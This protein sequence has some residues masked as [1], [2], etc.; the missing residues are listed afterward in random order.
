MDNKIINKDEGIDFDEFIAWRKEKMKKATQTQDL[1]RPRTVAEVAM[2]RSSER[3]LEAIAP[4]TGY[5]ELT[6][7]LKGFIPGHLYVLTGETNIGKS[8]IAANFAVRLAR[9]QKKVCYVALEPENTIVD[10]LASVRFDKKYEDLTE[11]DIKFDDGNIHIYG[12]EEI[13]KIGDLVT[14]V[15]E[16][17]RYDLII[18]DHISYFITGESQNIFV[19]QSNV[20]KKLA[21]LAKHKKTAIL[22]IA[23]L[24]KPPT[25]TNRNY[26]PTSDSISG[27]A[28]FKQDATDV[29]ILTRKTVD[30][31]SGGFDYTDEGT[32]FVVKTK[33]GPPG[34]VPLLFSDRKANIVSVGELQEMQ[35]QKITIK[36]D[37]SID[38][39]W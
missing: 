31:E 26:I 2:M 23:H 3:E 39:K 29:L 36:I 8:A 34:F 15:E 17:E 24:K 25:G 20:I 9:Q 22:L 32:L 38:E 16:G 10:Y 12:K 1:P 11:E 7:I 14:I 35:Q 18:V 27:S 30:N 37:N 19:E 6:Q 4:K 13:T 5:P 28:S 33:S 21:G